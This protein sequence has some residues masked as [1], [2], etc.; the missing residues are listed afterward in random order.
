MG[1]TRSARHAVERAFRAGEVTFIVATS[2]F[3]EGVNIPDVRDVV[4]YHLPF[5]EVEF[6]QM[7][8]RAGRDGAVAR[9]HPLFG[10][11]DGR[12]NEMIL[13]SA[14]PERDDMAASVPGA[15]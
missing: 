14:A 13:S 3:G 7:C 11:K 12:V 1:S 8:G 2:A 5:N 15:A 6:N 9:V 10:E 4:L